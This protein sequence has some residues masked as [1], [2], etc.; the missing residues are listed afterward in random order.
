V[1]VL[2]SGDHTPAPWIN[3]IA[4][5]RFGFQV[6]ESGAGYTW[7]ANSR[8]NQLT[9][10]LND[11]VGDTAG[12]AMYLYDEES[13]QAWTP[14]AAPIRQINGS[15][16]CRHGQGYSR[17]SH[18]S[19]GIRSELT[20]F[21][22]LEAPMKVI[23]LALEND[24]RSTR[25]IAVTNYAEW[26]LGFSR[27]TMAPTT[28]TEFDEE[29]AAIFAT[30]PRSNEYGSKVSFAACSAPLA[31]YTGDRGEFLGRNGSYGSPVGLRKESL[32]KRT[33]AA[34]DPCAALRSVLE[35]PAGE[36][37]EVVFY[38]GQADS[39]EE[40]RALLQ[41]ART[42]G[43]EEQFR[44]VTEYWEDTLTAVQVR[45]PDPA[46]DL[47]LNRWLGYQ[48]AVCR[49]WARAAFYQAGGA[50]GF[51]DQ[52][53]DVMALLY[54]RPDL[55]REHI[56]RAASRQ[57]AEGDVQHWWHPPLGRGVR[58]HFS[59][60]LLWLPYTVF[61][62][63]SVTGDRSVLDAE[64]SFLEGPAL[65]PDQE[66]SYYTPETSHSSGSIYEHCVRALD[67]SLRTGK[68]GLPFIGAGDWND[69][70]NRVGHGGE[71]E[72]V[73]LG[74]FLIVNLRQFATIA[75]ARGDTRSA[76]RWE[77]HAAFLV[78]QIEK[79]SWDGEWYRRAYFDDG[80]PIGSAKNEECRIDSLTQ[81]WAVI[82]GAGDPK[83][84]LTAMSS[85]EKMLVREQDKMILLFT[86]AFDKTPKDPGYI[87]GYLPG[88][89]EN[90][91]QY[92][93]A[94]IWCVIAET[95]LGRGKRAHELF[96]LLN[97]VR[98]AETKAEME[99]YKV[100][101]YVLAADVY[102]EAPHRG[103]GGWTW[104]TGS[105]GWMY[106]AGVENILGLR[107]RGHELSLR[108][109]IPAEWPGFEISYRYGRTVYRLTVKNP[110]KRERGK[111]KFGSGDVILMVDDGHAH[112]IEGVIV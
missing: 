106:R 47:M 83:R 26:V 29:S 57:F 43:A 89:R 54:S 22:D 27:A 66:D 64:A 88:V 102:S 56:L 8:E 17:F 35:I 68:H 105:C 91:G 36:K 46:M 61:Q 95:Y 12:E 34:M 38:L 41:T 76:E 75:R 111:V 30:N 73:W 48:T 52:L 16:V 11:P 4:N 14:T 3:V 70:M 107:V 24:S 19:H 78:D 100:E 81:T 44:R 67:R 86:P 51:R 37:R 55:A 15:Y 21:A 60:D 97:P 6:S 50:F 72:S 77:E 31:S 32:S 93:H 39:R 49:F 59:D 110:E 108:P 45:T 80:T 23:R 25:R 63:V 33:G 90:G 28:V 53:Q 104:Y 74:W 87:K 71:G 7:A 13:G 1:I 18:T 2:N 10:W 62:Y 96:S 101:P 84:A 20:F 98:H 85:V 9:P 112:D 79:H 99:L 103:R 82:S 58:T 92:T 5:P 65:R 109:V 42:S 69:G 94:A 40:A